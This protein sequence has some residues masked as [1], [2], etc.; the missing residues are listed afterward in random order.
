[1]KNPRFRL[2]QMLRDKRC[3][4]PCSS[5]GSTLASRVKRRSA[6][7]AVMKDMRSLPNVCTTLLCRLFSSGLGVVRC[8]RTGASQG[9]TMTLPTAATERALRLYV[10]VWN[11]RGRLTVTRSGAHAPAY[12]DDSLSNDG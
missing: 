9:F 1:M 11:A 3:F 10:G 4:L 8:F 5:K 7:S 6:L 12:S 2:D